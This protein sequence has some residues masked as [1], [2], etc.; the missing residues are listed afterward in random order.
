VTKFI[1]HFS[2]K[3][4]F[5]YICLC[6]YVICVYACVYTHICVCVCIYICIYI[7]TYIYDMGFVEVIFM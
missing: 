2:K 5:M 1:C 3:C 6:I 4:K 7:Y